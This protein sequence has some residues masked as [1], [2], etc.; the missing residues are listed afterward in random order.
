VP[1]PVV[2]IC[3]L[4]WNT[5]EISREAVRKLR[6]SDQGIAY[7]LL[8]R[9]NGSTDG[10]AEAV[11]ATDPAAEVDAAATNLG[12]A[13][14]MN[15]LFARTSASYVL[16]L[17]GD[18][19]L[20]DGALAAMVAAAQAHPDAGLVAPRLVRPDGSYEHSTWPLP[21]LRLSALYATGL[22]PFLPHWLAERWMFE[23]DW[24]HDRSRWVGWAVG[25]ALL[26]P[27]TVLERVGGFDERYFMYGEDVDWCWRIRDAGYRIWFEADAV[28]RHVGGASGEQRYVGG[29]VDAR[30]AAA[31]ARLMTARRGRLVG[32]LFRLLQ[33]L[34]AVRV[35]LSAKLRHDPAALAWARVVLRTNLRLPEPESSAS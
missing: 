25:A 4:T 13:A 8:V 15:S 24:R 29:G 20:E 27:R 11:A 18:A 5:R 34:I 26:V 33:M 2:D 21:S 12:F 3:M 1:T 31:S 17:N 35:G 9:D 16:A 28:V 32:W 23:S 6:D 7:R 10:T 14:G 30:K 19:W 22:R